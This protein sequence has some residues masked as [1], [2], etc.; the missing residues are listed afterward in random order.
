MTGIRETMVTPE[1]AQMYPLIAASLATTFEHDR[2]ATA[3]AHRSA[4]TATP[5]QSTRPA[6]PGEV[7]IRR[8][9]AGD[10]PALRR[11]GYLDSDPAA[12]RRLADAAGDGDVLIAESERGIEAARSLTGTAAVAD[13]FRPTAVHTSMLALR[14]EQIAAPAQPAHARL[15]A[16]RPRLH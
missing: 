5:A 9:R 11:L 14:A 8:A 1:E 13:P 2:I 4:V 6:R 7:V 10:A 15:S 16:L 3:A 12:G